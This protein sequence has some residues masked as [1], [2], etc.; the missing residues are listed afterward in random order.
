MRI[1]SG[2]F[3]GRAI[4]SPPTD[5]TRPITDRAKQSLFDALQECF[6]DQTVLDCF[7]GTGSMGLECLSRGAAHAVF[8]ERDRDALKALKQNLKQF[9]LLSSATVM[10]TDAYA[11]AD[12]LA[13]DGPSPFPAPLTIAFVDPPY[14]HLEDGF[15]RNKVDNLIRQLAAHCMVDGGII[16]VRHHSRVT[17]DG[18]A[19]GVKIVRELVYGDMTITW[20]TKA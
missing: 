8:I 19:L 10:N 15:T 17:L 14:I 1:I 3:G 2:R 9:E 16:S 7:C 4:V 12:A 18:P 13:A 11:L 6:V 5:K 20:A